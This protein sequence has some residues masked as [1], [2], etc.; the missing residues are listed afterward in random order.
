MIT[1]IIFSSLIKLIRLIG[2][3]VKAYE[4]ETTL[5][6]SNINV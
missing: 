6:T 5:I 2:E 4:Q 3:E 1:A